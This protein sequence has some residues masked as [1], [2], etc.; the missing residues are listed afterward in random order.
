MSVL[1]YLQLAATCSTPLSRTAR[2]NPRE[3]EEEE[4]EKH[5]AAL[6][7]NGATGSRRSAE[8]EASRV[9]PDLPPPLAWDQAPFTDH[10]THKLRNTAPTVRHYIILK[11]KSV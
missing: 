4:E 9:R 5:G 1:H 2:E 6:T 7:P 11:H 10:R 3:E 8:P